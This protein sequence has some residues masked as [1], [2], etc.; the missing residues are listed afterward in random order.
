MK[1]IFITECTKNYYVTKKPTLPSLAQVFYINYIYLF[2]Y[3]KSMKIPPEPPLPAY[4][5]GLFTLWY[6][7]KEL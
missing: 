2:R 7:S 4:V 1:Y 3:R 5:P 6:E